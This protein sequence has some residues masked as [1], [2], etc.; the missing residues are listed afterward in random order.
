MPVVSRRLAVPPSCADP[1]V[2]INR[3]ECGEVTVRGGG[4]GQDTVQHRG[5]LSSP[6]R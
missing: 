2:L 6:D 1:A 4:P 5:G 3:N